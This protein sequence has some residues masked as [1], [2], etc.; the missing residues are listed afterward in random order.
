MSSVQSECNVWAKIC[1]VV[2]CA[3]RYTSTLCGRKPH[4]PAGYDPDDTC[5]EGAAVE[6]HSVNLPILPSVPVE[7]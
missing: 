6:S 3:A 1:G 7:H 2:P 4:R 5:F